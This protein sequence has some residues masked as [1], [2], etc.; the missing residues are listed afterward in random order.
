M[1]YKE[2][3][4]LYHYSDAYLTLVGTLCAVFNAAGRIIWGRLYERVSFKPLYT[5]LLLGQTGLTLTL[6]L[7]APY[8]SLFAVW[9]MSTLFCTAGNSAVFPP[10]CIAIFGLK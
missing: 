9:V 3:G 7:V 1:S 10:L 2:I 8:P 5:Y 6:R 4:T